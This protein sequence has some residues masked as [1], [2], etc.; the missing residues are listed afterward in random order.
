MD[1]T[2]GLSVRFQL[3]HALRRRLNP[4]PMLAPESAIAPAK[5]SS[6]PQAVSSSSAIWHNSASSSIEST[7]TAPDERQMTFGQRLKRMI[8]D[9]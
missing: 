1:Q 5:I 8:R 6:T 7:T 4:A 2:I 9:I 3:R